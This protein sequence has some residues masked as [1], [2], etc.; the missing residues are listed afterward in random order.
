MLTII[1]NCI[2]ES[3]NNSSWEVMERKANKIEAMSRSNVF[4]LKCGNLEKFDNS[5]TIKEIFSGTCEQLFNYVCNLKKDDHQN[6]HE[7]I[8][9]AFIIMAVGS[10]KLIWEKIIC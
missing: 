3:G 6:N 4:Q 7:F 8:T 9:L 5:K 1:L 10:R 2:F